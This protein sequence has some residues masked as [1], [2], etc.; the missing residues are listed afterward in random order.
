MNSI[1]QGLLIALLANLSLGCNHVC[2]SP[3]DGPVLGGVDLVKLRESYSVD[4]IPV[5]GSK[6]FNVTFGGFHFLFTS[7]NNAAKFS[8][9]PE[10]FIPQLGGYCSWGLTGFDIHVDDPSGYAVYYVCRFDVIC[11]FQLLLGRCLHK[12][13]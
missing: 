5:V 6:E 4:P 3:S 7:A 10:M 12:L 2:S 9:N 13:N 11:V 8:S 1:F